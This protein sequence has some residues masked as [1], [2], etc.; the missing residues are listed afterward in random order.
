MNNSRRNSV[1]SPFAAT[2]C[3]IIAAAAAVAAIY[4]RLRYLNLPL[5]RDEGE[6][7]YSGQLLIDHVPPY[8][9]AYNMKF[10][11]TYG[12]YA[13]IMALFGQSI[14]AIHL[15]L[16][17]INCAAAACLYIIGQRLADAPAGALAAAFYLTLSLSPWVAGLSAHATHFVVLPILCGWAMLATAGSPMPAWRALAAGALF[18]VAVLMKQPAALFL[19]FGCVAVFRANAESMSLKNRAAACAIFIGGASI[20]VI[21]TVL[22][23]MLAGVGARFYQWT[24]QYAR[25]YGAELSIADGAR[26]LRAEL[27]QIIGCYWPIWLVALL[28]CFACAL[29]R[30]MRRHAVILLSFVISSVVAVCPGFYF[31]EHYFIL[32]LPAVA[33]VAAVTLRLPDALRLTGVASLSV[34][35]A[36][37][38]IVF[39]FYRERELLFDRSPVT[40]FQS[41]YWPNPFVAAIP[42]A[43]FIRERTSPSDSVAVLG[44]EPEIY[45][46]AHRHSATGYIYTYALME[47]HGRAAEMQREMAAEVEHSKPKYV[48]VVGVD[49]SWLRRASA[50]Q[51]IFNWAN[52]YLSRGYELA[53]VVN[54]VSADRTDFLL[55][56]DRPV[57]RPVENYLLVYLRRDALGGPNAVTASSPAE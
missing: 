20:P 52:D 11:G 34:A 6:Y 2:A 19:P 1:H 46:Y 17:I 55:P 21:G 48:V 18:G 23:L 32:V 47:P 33:L 42:I 37:G 35:I 44:S 41:L 36:A 45:F 29:L 16:L 51:W 28:G 25:A 3:G 53:G 12:A 4:V 13:I 40:L 31:R 8:K 10:P 22:A 43:K 9:L 15:G 57:E 38:I 49:T 39:P 27:P 30:K 5:E 26:L 54:L 56:V 7:A 24:F 14:A 50:D